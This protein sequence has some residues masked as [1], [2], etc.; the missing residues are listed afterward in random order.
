MEEIEAL[1]FRRDEEL[2]DHLRL[3]AGTVL[4]FTRCVAVAALRPPPPPCEAL[5]SELISAKP[6]LPSGREVAPQSDGR[7]GAAICSQ[8]DPTIFA[9]HCSPSGEGLR[10]EKRTD[11]ALQ[12][13]DVG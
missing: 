3:F 6:S 2:E 11:I 7:P 12:T 4:L 1:G 5:A 10:S 8:R 13:W 9:R